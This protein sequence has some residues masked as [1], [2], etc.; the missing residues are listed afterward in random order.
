MTRYAKAPEHAYDADLRAAVLAEARQT[1][2]AEIAK[3]MA[4]LERAAAEFPAI[5]AALSR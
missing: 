3:G 4:W 5:A 2:G 1:A